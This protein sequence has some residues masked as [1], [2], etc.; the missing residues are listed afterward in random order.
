M[1]RNIIRRRIF[2]DPK[3]NWKIQHSDNRDIYTSTKYKE[4]NTD[5]AYALAIFAVNLKHSLLTW[6]MVIGGS[7]Y[8][9]Y[10]SKSMRKKFDINYLTQLPT[11]DFD[12]ADYDYKFWEMVLSVPDKNIGPSLTTDTASK[13]HYVLLYLGSIQGEHI[14]MQRFARLQR[15]IQAR[16]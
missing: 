5:S 9:L 6:T 3:R 1:L 8:V 13:D 2:Y 14:P 11:K 4:Y 15:F 12:E 7:L 10:K 16:K